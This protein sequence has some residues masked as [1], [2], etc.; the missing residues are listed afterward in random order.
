MNKTRSGQRCF[1]RRD[2]LMAAAGSA[3]VLGCGEQETAEPS[4]AAPT[5]A[6]G[7]PVG[8]QLYCFRHLLEEDF[9]GTLEQVATL[10]YDGVE[11]AGYYDYSADE[12]RQLL[13]GHGLGVAG[14][15]VGIEAL[16]GDEL[17]PSID[18]HGELGNT[19][20]IVPAI[21]EERHASV[22]A[23]MRTAEDLTG[24]QEALRPH[25]MS[26]GYHCHAYSFNKLMDGKTVW[27]MLADNTPE[28]LILQLDTGNAANGGADVA[29][30]INNDPG[31]IRSMHLKPFT[32][33]AEAPF[34]PFIG[35]DGL[36]WAE[37]LDLGESVGGIEYYVVEYE[38]ESHPPL[39]ALRENRERLAGFGR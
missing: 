15:H 10:G 1:T 17:Q 7:V 31:R 2:F 33:G 36:P 5:A 26:T 28:D 11:F 27:D 23:L 22:D 14:A 35:D 30:I 9:E 20:L 39:D 37:I 21:S 25:G 3:L 4:P 16:L 18:F 38:E 24:I 29:Q 34:A 12:L 19:R 32:A 6:S 8:V 13:Q